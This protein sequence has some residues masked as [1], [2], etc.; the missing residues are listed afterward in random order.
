MAPDWLEAGMEEQRR[1]GLSRA[2]FCV[3]LLDLQGEGTP[4][5]RLAYLVGAFIATDLEALIPRGAVPGD[6]QVVISGRQAIAEA[7]AFA[8]DRISL[9][10]FV[11]SD[12]ETEK[13]FLSGL[14]SILTGATSPKD[15]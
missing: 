1:S 5:D 6:I 4:Q 8:L 9:S 14:N 15:Q 3:R 10:T 11:L 2:L 7:W 13:A 12:E